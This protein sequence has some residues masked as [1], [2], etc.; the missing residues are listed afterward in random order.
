MKALRDALIALAALLA[1]ATLAVAGVPTPTVEIANPDAHCVA[2]PA[3]MRR[4]HMEMLRHQ[5]DRTMRLGERG[6][7]VSLNAC[8][9]CHASRSTG[10]VIGA[11]ADFCASCHRY[12]AVTLDCFECHQPKA[13]MASLSTSKEPSQ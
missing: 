3:E 1:T 13:S 8:I 7:A 9:D 11:E 6:A 2:P 5:R 12:A 4:N 10:S